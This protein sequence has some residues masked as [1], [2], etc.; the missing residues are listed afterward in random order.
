MRDG[1]RFNK[2]DKGFVQLEDIQKY[3]TN[4]FIK[5]TWTYLNI[6]FIIIKFIIKH[7]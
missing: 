1:R 2:K 4:L 5:V 7:C 6:I 3:I